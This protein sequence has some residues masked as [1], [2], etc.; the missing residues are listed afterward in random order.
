MKELMGT[1]KPQSAEEAVTLLNKIKDNLLDSPLY[2][3][4]KNGWEI[5]SR[6]GEL[7]LSATK[8][9]S[10]AYWPNIFM[11]MA[12]KEIRKEMNKG[13]KKPFCK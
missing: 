10:D 2:N 13:T 4:A 8:T 1:E 5:N 3:G 11:S 9:V 7:A 6:I 12:E